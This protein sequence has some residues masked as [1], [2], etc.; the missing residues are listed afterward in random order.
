M[1]RPKK[2][3]NSRSRSFLLPSALLNQI[4]AAAEKRKIEASD[5]V[6][7]LLEAN[8]Q[9][10]LAE[11]EKIWQQH[12][13]A[14]VDEVKKDPA[15]FALYMS[16]KDRE[17]LVLP[18]D[19]GMRKN[20]L[21]LLMEALK[22]HRVLKGVE[23]KGRQ[24]PLDP[25]LLEMT[26]GVDERAMKCF[27]DLDHLVENGRVWLSKDAT[28]KVLL[29]AGEYVNDLIAERRMDDPEVESLRALINRKVLK[30]VGTKRN[31]RVTVYTRRT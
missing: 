28:G 11:S 12:L 5:V 21:L 30:E 2:I 29:E 17:E 10:Y 22:A 15:V 16:Y 1:G 3:E 26:K 4:E 27:L 8:I 23:S 9:E 25:L 31:D 7:D 24:K 20:Q 6:R 18:L 19:T 14:A 13:R